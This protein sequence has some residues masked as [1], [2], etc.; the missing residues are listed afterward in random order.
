[1]YYSSTFFGTRVSSSG[2]L[3]KE[4]KPNKL[5]KVLIV[6]IEIIKILKFQNT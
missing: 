2:I 1:M 3:S 6:L 5:I 4:Y